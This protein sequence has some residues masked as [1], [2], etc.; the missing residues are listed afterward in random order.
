M[1]GF[2][3]LLRLL[4]SVSFIYWYFGHSW[5]EVENWKKS[6]FKKYEKKTSGSLKNELQEVSKSNG[7]NTYISD[8]DISDTDLS[9][10]PSEYSRNELE[11]SIKKQT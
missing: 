8:T 9:F 1:D 6:N 11:R 5:S 3:S 10:I 2:F 7:T 4:V